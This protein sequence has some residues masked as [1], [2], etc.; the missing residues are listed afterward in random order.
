MLIMFGPTFFGGEDSCIC[1]VCT[2]VI[3]FPEALQN[4][5]AWFVVVL[6][7]ARLLVALGDL[8]VSLRFG[9][10]IPVG[11]CVYVEDVQRILTV[12]FIAWRPKGTGMLLCRRIN[13]AS[14]SDWVKFPM[15]GSRP[16]IRDVISFSGI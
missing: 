2:Q 12:V 8:S 3:F 9:V 4:P 7:R 6:M 1:D 5:E 16:G 11:S 14:R 15:V 13:C 10:V